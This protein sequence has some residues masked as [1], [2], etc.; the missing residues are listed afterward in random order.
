MSFVIAQANTQFTSPSA[1][2]ILTD[3]TLTSNSS[4]LLSTL[5]APHGPNMMGHQNQ[6]THLLHNATKTE[7]KWH[8]KSVLRN[9]ET[10]WEPHPGMNA[11]RVNCIH[12]FKRPWMISN[13]QKGWVEWLS[14]YLKASIVNC[15]SVCGSLLTSKMTT[16][17][18][19][20]ASTS[21]LNELHCC[22][23]QHSVHKS[24]ST[25]HSHWH[26][27]NF[28]FVWSCFSLLSLLLMDPGHQNQST[29][30]LHIAT[31]DT[32]KVALEISCF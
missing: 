5:L 29:L 19:T 7:M 11:L 32:N 22:S 8:W 31:K 26:H 14:N 3:F 9:L 28:N 20:I 13:K 10:C 21:Q 30:L 18:K 27:L 6:S 25:I 12:S 17:E 2:F 24:L 15:S 1:P 4:G 23:S 16:Q